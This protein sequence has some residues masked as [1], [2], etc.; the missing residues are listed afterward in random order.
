M[1]FTP[2]EIPTTQKLYLFMADGLSWEDTYYQIGDEDAS[3]KSNLSKVYINGVERS[4]NDTATY[5][6]KNEPHHVVLV[7]NDT[8]W[9]YGI[10]HKF[11]LNAGSNRHRYQMLAFYE[12]ELTAGKVLEHYNLLI[13]NAK[14]SVTEPAINMTE[15]ASEYYNNDWVLVKSR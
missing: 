14:Y 12:N 5:F 11:G 1:I 8:G 6:V 10:Q 3:N 7:V 13:G 4:G 15:Y 2:V 9:N